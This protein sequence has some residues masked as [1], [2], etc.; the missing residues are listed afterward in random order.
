[1]HLF[2]IRSKIALICLGAATILFLAA[3][4]TLLGGSPAASVPDADLARLTIVPTQPK[5][6]PTSRPQPTATVA[7]IQPPV[8]IDGQC[9]TPGSPALPSKPETMEAVLPTLTAYLN[10]GGNAQNIQTAL[11]SWGYVGTLSATHQT[12]GEV[13]QMSLLAHGGKQWVVTFI[14]PRAPKADDGSIGALPGDVAVLGCAAGR[15][16]PVYDALH[17]PTFPDGIVPSPRLVKDEDVTGDGLADLSFATGECVGDACYDSLNIV[18]A[19]AGSVADSVAR[20]DDALHTISEQIEPILSPTWRFIPDPAHHPGK[21]L[22]AVEGMSHEVEAGPQRVV[23]DTW[24]FDG[25]VFTRTHSESAPASYRIHALQ[26]GDDALRGKDFA[27]ADTL[28]QQVVF[29]PQ[30]KSWESMSNMQD[31]DRVLAAFALLRLLQTSAAHDDATSVQ[32]AYEALVSAVP[33]GGPGEVYLRM[34]KVFFDTFTQTDNYGK[35]CEVTIELA[36]AEPDSYGQ[37]G[38]ETFGY[39]N[40]DYAAEDMCLLP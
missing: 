28:Y 10:S 1:M 16:V 3:C 7:A 6:T 13:R 33:V 4:D 5:A 18:S 40:A 24:L 15:Y 26:D 19:A 37:L 12:L 32:S 38:P 23:T 17:D 36:R 2:M 9:P 34:G 21:L 14:D 39:S 35:A 11:E 31:E 25:T 8:A 27:A 30:L 29:D 22:L 20:T